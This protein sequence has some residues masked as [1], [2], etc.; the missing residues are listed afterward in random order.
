MTKLPFSKL[1][2]HV[3]GKIWLMVIILESMHCTTSLSSL[4]Q[5]HSSSSSMATLQQFFSGR[6][7]SL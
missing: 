3:L 7:F 4:L 5:R 1:K 2:D 6:R